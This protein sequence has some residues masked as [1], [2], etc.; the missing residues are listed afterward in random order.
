MSQKKNPAV[1]ANPLVSPRLAEWQGDDRF[2]RWMQSVLGSPEGQLLLAVLEEYSVPNANLF[3]IR[4]GVSLTEKLA[5][6][7][8]HLSGIHQ[9]AVILRMLAQDPEAPVVEPTP[10]G[11]IAN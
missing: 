8:A 11:H 1:T 4:E 5:L 6:E 10:W 2:Q 7:H 3:S 9:A